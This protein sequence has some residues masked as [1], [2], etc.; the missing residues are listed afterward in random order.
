MEVATD[1][2]FGRTCIC[3]APLTNPPQQPSAPSAIRGQLV[4]L[5]GLLVTGGQLLAYSLNALFYHLP[6]G[7]RWMV[8]AGAVPAAAQLIGLF[9]LD[10]SPRWYV[11]RGR[12]SNARKVLQKIY[13][14]A[15]F[16]QIDGQIKRIQESFAS[17]T[18]YQALAARIAATEAAAAAEAEARQRERENVST[19]GRPS[20]ENGVRQ[21]ADGLRRAVPLP[22]AIIP[23]L[24][25]VRRS[26]SRARGK[27]GQLFGERANRRALVLAC[28]L[29]MFQQLCGFNSLMYFSGRLLLMAGF[30]NPNA[31]AIGIAAAN[32]LGT[33]V[34]MRLVDRIGRRALLLYTTAAAAVALAFLAT[35]LG[36]VDMKDVVDSVP[37]V[38]AES[39]SAGSGSGS[40]AGA[41]APAQHLGWAYASLAGMILFTLF[42]AL[43]LGIIPW[44]VQAEVFAS[45]VRGIGG[46]FATATN[47][48]SQLLVS[49]T[50]LDL[51]KLI[52]AAGSFWLYSGVTAASC[53]FTYFLLPEL[54]GVSINDVAQAFDA[55]EQQGRGEYTAVGQ[56]QDD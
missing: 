25:D 43:G 41:P 16:A 30:A 39:V 44:L 3:A 38:L 18:A 47:W 5:N 34:A 14:K 27:F 52:T 51:V 13:P 35:S 26:A 36:M 20:L 11:S 17:D 50:Y 53:V 22:R 7:W 24:P 37:P 6:H 21:L 15:S 49:A 23:P 31:T 40:S 29:Q 8:L 42:Y 32:L 4:G 54:S 56:S 12:I 10:D 33:A 46:G 2:H 55:D 45:P 28:G 9:A 1:H 19:S 48:T